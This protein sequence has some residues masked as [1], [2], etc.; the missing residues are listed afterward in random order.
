[1][2]RPRTFPVPF[3]FSC[4]CEDV[5]KHHNASKGRPTWGKISLLA[6]FKINSK[7]PSTENSLDS[8]STGIIVTTMPL[9]FVFALWS[10][11]VISCFFVYHLSSSVSFKYYVKFVI[12]LQRDCGQKPHS[13]FHAYR[14][15][16]FLMTPSCSLACE[17]LQ[18]PSWRGP[19][20]NMFRLQF[21]CQQHSL[22]GH[23]IALSHSWTL[24][25]LH[26][27]PSISPLGHKCQE[28]SLCE[29]RQA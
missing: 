19:V 27:F 24:A 5:V 2:A 16:K 25:R 29:M 11:V 6:Y 10:C 3:W 26:V 18:I 4:S 22:H 28:F 23:H 8:T 13:S 20:L 14:L 15:L 17:P 9:L 21:S 7:T 1:M 12:N